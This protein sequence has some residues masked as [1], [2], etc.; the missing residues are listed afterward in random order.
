MLYFTPVVVLLRLWWCFVITDVAILW[1]FIHLSRS[2]DKSLPLYLQLLFFLLT[3]A[4]QSSIYSVSI[5]YW[6]FTSRFYFS[7]IWTFLILDFWPFVRLSDAAILS[8]RSRIS[9][10]HL[11][12]LCLEKKLCHFYLAQYLLACNYCLHGV[13]CT[14]LIHSR[15]RLRLAS[16]TDVVVPATRRSSLGDRAKYFWSQEHGHGTRYRPVSPPR[17]LSRHPGDFWQLFC[18]RNNCM[19]NVNYCLVVLKCLYTV[20]R[21]SWRTELKWTVVLLITTWLCAQWMVRIKVI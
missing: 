6:L 17:C 5:C 19:D 10:T 1:S 11:Y 20:P 18:F 4:I 15:Q 9:W 16:S 7:T 12:T 21:Y 14:L 3:T 8:K 13:V 2:G